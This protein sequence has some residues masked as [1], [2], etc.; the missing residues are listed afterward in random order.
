MQYALDVII[1]KSHKYHMFLGSIIGPDLH[2]YINVIIAGQ[3]FFT[4]RRTEPRKE[5]NG[6]KLKLKISTVFVPFSVDVSIHCIF[7]CL[8]HV[9]YIWLSVIGKKKKREEIEKKNLLWQSDP[10]TSPKFTFSDKKVVLSSVHM[11]YPHTKKLWLK[12]VLQ[13]SHG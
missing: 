10:W 5:P 2:T 13:K 3:F 4:L 7:G 1:Q 8:K 6:N 12:L 9:Y 11:S